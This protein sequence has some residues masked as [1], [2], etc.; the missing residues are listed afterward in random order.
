MQ[1]LA[2]PVKD[3]AHG[4]HRLAGVLSPAERSRLI[5]AMLEG[6]LIAAA[7]QHGW[8][9]WVVARS[10]AVLSRARRAGARPV[11]ETGTS[12]HRAIAQVE[13][14][15]APGDDDTLAVLLADLPRITP[16]GLRAALIESSTAPVAAV[17]AHS[18][19]GTNLLVRRP[20]SIIPNRFGR[21]SFAEHRAEASR[22]R[23]VF[24]DVPNE[25]LAFDLDTPDDLRRWLASAGAGPA[26]AE[27]LALGLPERLSAGARR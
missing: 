21:A 26:Y 15:L 10:G 20:P 22:A 17:A 9:V 5:L 13:A 11:P 25:E 18:D 23:V 8:D 27:A 2:V 3:L 4:K 12:L 6:V 16:A 19:G 24:L 7:A 14:E 1:V